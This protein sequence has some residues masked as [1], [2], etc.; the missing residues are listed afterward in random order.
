M[1]APVDEARGER[2]CPERP[3]LA[4]IGPAHAVGRMT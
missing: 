1:R 3:P 2:E 4:A